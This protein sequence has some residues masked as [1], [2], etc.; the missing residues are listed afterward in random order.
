ME[1]KT[2]PILVITAGKRRVGDHNTDARITFV[3]ILDS[4]AVDDLPCAYQTIINATGTFQ[5]TCDLPT[6][7]RIS[8]NKGKLM[9]R[10]REV[11]G[12][13]CAVLTI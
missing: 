4:A 6:Y 3:D 13:N 9:K 1:N 10:Q 2:G 5:E 8:D 7:L 12:N 11:Y